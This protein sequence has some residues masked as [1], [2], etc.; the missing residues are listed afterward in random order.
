MPALHP[1]RRLAPPRRAGA[2]ATLA[3]LAAL[4]G[5]GC[6][7]ATAPADLTGAYLLRTVGGRTLPAVLSSER[8]AD[9]GTVT[10][11]LLASSFRF[12]PGGAVRY[13]ATLRNASDRPARDTTFTVTA[14]LV[15]RRAG[16]RVTISPA[17]PCPPE[18]LCGGTFTGRLAGGGLEVEIGAA[19]AVRYR[20]EATPRAAAP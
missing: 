16:A 6:G 8:S 18:A 9:G 2:A 12:E 14:P 20:Y 5:A 13:D 7:E 1:A 17:T 4:A 10:I 11:T 3:V 19:P 15:Y